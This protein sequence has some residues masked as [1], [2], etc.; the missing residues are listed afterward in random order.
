[1][2][3]WEWWGW[4]VSKCY[5]CTCCVLVPC[6]SGVCPPAAHTWDSSKVCLCV[7]GATAWAGERARSSGSVCSHYRPPASFAQWLTGTG[8]CKPSSLAIHPG[9]LSGLTDPRAPMGSGWGWVSA[10]IHCITW[11]VLTFHPVS[12]CLPPSLVSPDGASLINHLHMNPQLRV[13][14][15]DT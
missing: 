10:S 8:V 2:H 5:W 6:V 14:F 9:K 13:C 11:L 4:R 15:W 12:L 7:A 3:I 1:M